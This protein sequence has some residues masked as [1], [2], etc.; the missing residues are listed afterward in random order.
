MGRIS[1]YGQAK[2]E[3]LNQ[4]AELQLNVGD[5]LPPERALCKQ[6]NVSMGTMRLALEDMEQ[7]GF[8]EKRH[9]IGSFLM[10]PLQSRQCHDTI[11]FIWIRQK[12]TDRSFP[13]IAKLRDYLQ[14]RGVG[15]NYLEVNIINDG[16]AEAVSGSIGVF[17]CG[18]IT[19]E[20]AEFFRMFE[21]PT[22]VLGSNRYSDLLPTIAQDWR[23]SA[24]KLT[25]AMLQRGCK[26][27][28]L[29]NGGKDYYP[30]ELL[31]EGY[32]QV[33]ERSCCGYRQNLVLWPEPAT[34]CREI[35]NFLL[36][37]PE[38][39]GVVIELGNLNAFFTCCWNIKKETDIT[40]GIAG[41]FNDKEDNLEAGHKLLL[42]GFQGATFIVGAEFF[43]DG[44]LRKQLFKNRIH[45]IDSILIGG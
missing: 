3:V 25:D 20:W 38:V 11:T 22:I 27:I 5:C 39:D 33:L 44:A 16:I 26:N 12:A 35:H 15:L 28:A 4:I 2:L 7:S 32:R 13:D 10:K 17:V 23:G 9:G 14:Q 19:K 34:R 29:I 41:E 40:V 1:K 31:H 24:A 8:I 42:S 36:A 45:W 18:W 43:F 6:C 30:S 21:T 37:A